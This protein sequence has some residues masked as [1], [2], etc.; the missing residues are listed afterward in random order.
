MG[1]TEGGAPV[2]V[3]EASATG[4]PVVASFHADIPEVVRHG[5][6][7]WLAPERDVEA[8]AAHLVGLIEHP[9]SWPAMGERGRRHIEG[10]VT[11]RS[12]PSAWMTSTTKFGAREEGVGN[13]E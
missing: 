11:C 2:G 8:L 1:D 7:G 10:R 4:M 9:E 6:S 5:E 13:R 12:R 3:I